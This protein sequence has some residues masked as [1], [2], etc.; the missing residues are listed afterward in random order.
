M[1]AFLSTAVAI[2]SVGLRTARDAGTAQMAEAQAEAEA[3]NLK[4]THEERRLRRLERLRE[5]LAEQRV[6]AGVRGR[7]GSAIDGAA[8]ALA[9]R[10]ADGDRARFNLS[11]AMLDIRRRNARRRRAVGGYCA[12]ILGGDATQPAAL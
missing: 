3:A 2:A 5:Q 11:Y 10:E 4:L 12:A 7:G 9:Q 8:R 1:G 6:A